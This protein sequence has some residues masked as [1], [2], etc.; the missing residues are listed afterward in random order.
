MTGI[1]LELGNEFLTHISLELPATIARV[2][3]L[4]R[5]KPMEEYDGNSSW[6]CN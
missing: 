4:V 6:S 2:M 3:G 1:E 5:V